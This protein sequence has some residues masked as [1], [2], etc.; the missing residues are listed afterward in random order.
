MM[1]CKSGERRAAKLHA[2]KMGSD[3]IKSLC[4]LAS[5]GCLESPGWTSSAICAD[6]VTLAL[7]QQWGRV[8]PDAIDFFI[9]I[10]AG[11]NYHLCL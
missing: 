1:R 9:K 5:A 8:V 2:V 10:V 6:T 11:V 7:C 3:I 4:V